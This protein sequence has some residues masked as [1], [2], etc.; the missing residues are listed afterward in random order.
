MMMNDT[1]MIHQ[2]NFLLIRCAMFALPGLQGA[3]GSPFGHHFPA[4]F[5]LLRQLH[6][7]RHFGHAT[8]RLLGHPA[9]GNVCSDML[10]L[11]VT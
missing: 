6:S 8:S 2:G 5:L 3:S 11:P 7:H 1:L 10:F 4:Q 9:G